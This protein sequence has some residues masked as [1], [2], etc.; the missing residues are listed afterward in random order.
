MENL[1]E[2]GFKVRK[3]I[4]VP[5]SYVVEVGGRRYHHNKHDLTLRHPSDDG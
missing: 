4:G 2:K 1:W 5:D 3:V